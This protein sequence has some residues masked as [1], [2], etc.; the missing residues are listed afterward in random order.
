MATTH[1]ISKL[2]MFAVEVL[3]FCGRR[4]P[5]VTVLLE[6]CWKLPIDNRVD[7]HTAKQTTSQNQPIE[8]ILAA[9]SN[10]SLPA[11]IQWINNIGAAQAHSY[12]PFSQQKFLSIRIALANFEYSSM[13]TLISGAHGNQHLPELTTPTQWIGWVWSHRKGKI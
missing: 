7:Q 12:S 5:T 1:S 6:Q 11:I 9:K 13:R 3:L 2:K 10:L 8:F 4:P